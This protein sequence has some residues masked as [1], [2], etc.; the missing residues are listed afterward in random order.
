MAPSS[1]RRT[2]TGPISA[3]AFMLRVAIVAIT[4][5]T[6][7]PAMPVTINAVMLLSMLATTQSASSPSS[8]TGSG[9]GV[10]DQHVPTSEVGTTA[11][12]GASIPAAFRV[13][14]SH[15]VLP[16]ITMRHRPI[17]MSTPTKIA[18]TGV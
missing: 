17:A 16:L 2:C 18:F 14:S 13:A 10:T 4:A 15:E 6:I 1:P 8:F 3:I 7:S 9:L 11:T 5:A 12:I